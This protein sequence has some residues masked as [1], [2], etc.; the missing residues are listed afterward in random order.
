[1]STSTLKN[2][3]SDYERQGLRNLSPHGWMG[4]GASHLEPS[5]TVGALESILAS[6]LVSPRNGCGFA[7]WTGARPLHSPWGGGLLFKMITNST[8]VASFRVGVLSAI[9][10]GTE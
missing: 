1:M 9:E 6:H 4:T 3:S 2:T 7:Q 5:S 8:T 10:N